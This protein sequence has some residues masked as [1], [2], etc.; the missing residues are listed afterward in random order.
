MGSNICVGKTF[1]RKIFI[2]VYLIDYR[3]VTDEP[4]IWTKNYFFNSQP[5]L[6]RWRDRVPDWQGRTQG[7]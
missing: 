1:F 2:K 4:Q 5:H 6:V 3:V 7:P